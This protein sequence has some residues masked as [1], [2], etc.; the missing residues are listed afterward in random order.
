MIDPWTTFLNMIV[1]Q[2]LRESAKF[3][4]KGGQRILFLIDE[5]AR[6]GRIRSIEDSMTTLRSKGITIC[7]LTQSISQIDAIY[8]LEHR[9]IIMDNAA[10]TLVLSARDPA[11]A[12]EISK[13]IGKDWFTKVSINTKKMA[14]NNYTYSKQL[15]YIV[16]P[17]KLNNL[18]NEMILISKDGFCKVEKVNIFRDA[19]PWKG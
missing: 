17:E 18:G 5:F 14:D 4:D 11:S 2:F 19:F 12:E 8:G 3:P 10:Y 7:L 15:V 13:M 9:R 1:N 16:P 6:L